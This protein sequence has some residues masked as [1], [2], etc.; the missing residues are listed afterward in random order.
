MSTRAGALTLA[1]LCGVA[2]IMVATLAPAGGD[3]GVKVRFTITHGLTPADFAGAY[4]AD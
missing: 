2:T 1:A 4:S 3:E